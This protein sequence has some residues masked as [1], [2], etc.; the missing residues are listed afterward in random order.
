M[1][2]QIPYYGQGL[3]F[4]C[5]ILLCLPTWLHRYIL[6]YSLMHVCGQVHL[7]SDFDLFFLLSMSKDR[8]EK[9]GLEWC[10]YNIFSSNPLQG[11][12][13]SL[14]TG[15]KFRPAVLVG[16]KNFD[17]PFSS[18]VFLRQC[19]FFFFIISTLGILIAS[20]SLF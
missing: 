5:K 15:K 6:N 1:K 19:Y 11:W 20:Q 13:I 8:V 12:T 16:C 17:R 3:W 4:L 2:G 14:D 9:M 18:G 7:Y 10:H